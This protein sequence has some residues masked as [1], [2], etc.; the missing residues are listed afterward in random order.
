MAWGLAA[1]G[2]RSR[3]CRFEPDGRGALPYL[4]DTQSR[5]VQLVVGGQG[6]QEA[7]MAVLYVIIIVHHDEGHNPVLTSG[8]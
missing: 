5:T 7:E 4:S 3:T 2:Q 1:G 8:H 6:L